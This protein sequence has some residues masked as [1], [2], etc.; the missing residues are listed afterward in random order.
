[1]AQYRTDLE[2]INF[3][4][5]DLLK[6]EQFIEGY[7]ANDLKDIVREYDKFIEKEVAPFRMKGD[8]E[9]V[10]LENG[11][12]LS[13]KCF[14][15]P[16][17]GYYANGWF[18]LGLPEEF[19][20]MPVPCAVRSA[21]VSL[22]I[23]AN[24]GWTMY[25]GLS[26]AVV[27]VLLQIGT[28]EQQQTYIPGLMEGKWSGTMCLT[29]PAAG[30]DVGAVKTTATP[31]DNGSHKIKGIKIFISGGDTDLYESVVH[32][33]LARTPGA[34]EG[35]KGLSLFIVPKQL[36]NGSLNNV[37]CTK[38]EEKMGLHGSATCEMTFGGEG[39]CTGYLIG[40]E[41]EGMKNMFIMMNEA[42]LLCGQ[43]GEGQINLMYELT[44]QY[45]NERAQFGTELVNLPDIKRT[46]LKLRT[47]GRGIRGLV[48]YTANLFSRI[49]NGETE[50]EDE[51]AFLTPIC[52]AYGTDKGFEMSG[53]A[54]QVHGGYGF[55]T[56]YGVE[57]FVRDTKIGQIYEGT[58][59]IQ[60]IDFLMRKNLKEGGKTFSSI[61]KK[62]GDS[63]GHP[64]AEE[65]PIE[66]ELLQTCMGDVAK[67]LTHFGKLMADKKSDC[68]LS[69]AT[70]F[71]TLSGNLF[72][73]WR[74]WV[75]ACLA[76]EKNAEQPK[77]YYKSKEVDFSFFCQH[78][79]TQNSALAA[80]ILN[81]NHDW[82]H[83]EV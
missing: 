13:P 48:L 45:A 10:R 76:S 51:I 23:G 32:I 31:A 44:K 4:L 21:C 27:N 37:T 22:G 20:G 81:Y 55:C 46:L 6:T 28:E 77:S 40:K 79:L 63:L 73:A 58:N 65:Y 74:L 54:V 52:K 11:K 2:D 16:T 53:E 66:I 12:V 24:V 29:E 67:M 26:V 19:G 68:V 35:T 75:A 71:T 70:D 1:M 49:E 78:T 15:S 34:A 82:V 47:T 7:E 60:S 69:C 41:F 25:Y 39:D 57:Q 72:V 64:L 59:G 38:V 50:L 33:V 30:S 5:F 61:I 62:I 14:V 43:Q 18:G 9:G 42:R 80:R 3:T 56:E 36:E 83:G 17:A 8:E